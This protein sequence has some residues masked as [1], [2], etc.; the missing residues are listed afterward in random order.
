MEQSSSRNLDPVSNVL[1]LFSYGD[2]AYELDT[3]P[4]EDVIEELLPVLNGMFDDTIASL[5]GGPLTRVDVLDFCLS[6]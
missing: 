4:E 1:Q 5:Y 6:P 2:R 3:K